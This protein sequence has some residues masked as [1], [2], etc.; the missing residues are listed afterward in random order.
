MRNVLF[1][2]RNMLK[3]EHMNLCML[4]SVCMHISYSFHSLSF[5]LHKPKGCNARYSL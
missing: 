2:Q 3:G 4:Y 5:L 1:V